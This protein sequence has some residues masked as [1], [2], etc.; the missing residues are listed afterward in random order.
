[1]KQEFRQGRYPLTLISFD[2]DLGY[3]VPIFK[4]KCLGYISEILLPL[5]F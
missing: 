3:P 5:I 2:N 1:M 4:I